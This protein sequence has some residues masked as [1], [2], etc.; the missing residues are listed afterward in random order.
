MQGKR[1]YYVFRVV[2]ATIVVG[3]LVTLLLLL[4]NG[5]FNTIFKK[6]G[7]Y[8]ESESYTALFF[9]DAESLAKESEYVD[10]LKTFTFG[11]YNHENEDQTYSFLVDVTSSDIS[12]PV[13]NGTLYAKPGETVY[14]NV[15]LD[16][17]GYPKNSIVSVTL[18]SH[19]KSI[20]FEIN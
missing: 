11:V 1:T 18:P 4:E 20:D 17:A 5:Y 10:N 8:P 6:I 3:S 15:E 13:T 14:Y 9:V 16:V 2:A 12:T 7:V 19:Q